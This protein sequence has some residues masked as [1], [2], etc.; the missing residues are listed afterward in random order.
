[1]KNYYE[2]LEVAHS[3]TAGEI[4]IAYRKLASTYHPDKYPENTKFAEDMMKHINAAF[5][6][7]SDSNKRDQYD[8]WLKSQGTHAGT[9]PTGT[10]GGQGGA[11]PSDPTVNGSNTGFRKFRF[12]LILLLVITLIIF[13]GNY[14]RSNGDRRDSEMGTPLRS[15]NGIAVGDKLSDIEFKLGKLKRIDAVVYWIESQYDYIYLDKSDRVY[16]VAHVCASADKTLVLGVSCWDT[17]D[18]IKKLFGSKLVI[19]CIKTA[20]DDA[21]P[22]RSYTVREYGIRLIL[23]KGRVE[24]IGIVSL[25]D[26]G[27]DTKDVVSCS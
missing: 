27:K 20:A 22:K 17:S 13:L 4:K 1:M 5:G 8:A 18:K 15:L 21:D 25:D 12:V 11:A 2:I 6:V 3:A 14:L 9:Q 26:I 24:T 10:T 16:A 23:S 19:N 7:L